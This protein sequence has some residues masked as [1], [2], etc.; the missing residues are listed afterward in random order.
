MALPYDI[1]PSR[2]REEPVMLRHVKR[3]LAPGAAAIPGHKQPA[4]ISTGM[5]HTPET[6]VLRVKRINGNGAN[7]AWDTRLPGGCQEL[8]CGATVRAT[9]QAHT[10]VGI[11][12][13]I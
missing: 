3:P 11:S 13:K 9:V 4:S 12:R 1:W 8:P 10:R 2:A 6:D 7:T 5:G